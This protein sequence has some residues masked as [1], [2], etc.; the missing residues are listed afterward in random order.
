MDFYIFTFVFP[1]LEPSTV[2]QSIPLKWHNITILRGLC[3]CNC[4][5]ST[6]KPFKKKLIQIPGRVHPRCVGWN[7]RLW[8][9]RGVLGHWFQPSGTNHQQL[10][11]GR[12][13]AFCGGTYPV[14]G[15]C[16]LSIQFPSLASHDWWKR[17]K[18]QFGPIPPNIQRFP[19]NHPAG[20]LYSQAK[21]SDVLF[22]F[23]FFSFTFPKLR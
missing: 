5:L 21:Y 9:A 22:M 10:W 18:L 3:P 19:S 16:F 8:G 6:M 1:F 23:L 17:A 15:T 7:M 11:Q 20:Q 13:A 12:P 14:V 4:G 2:L